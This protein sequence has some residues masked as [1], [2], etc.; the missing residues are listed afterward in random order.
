MIIGDYTDQ[1]DLDRDFEPQMG[2][3]NIFLTS[4]EFGAPTW[5][6]SDSPTWWYRKGA[7]GPW[8]ENWYHQPTIPKDETHWRFSVP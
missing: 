1:P 5:V 4:L 7:M 6:A 2:C 3:A 8:G